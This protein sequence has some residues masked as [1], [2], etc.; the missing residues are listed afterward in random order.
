MCEITFPLEIQ[1]PKIP[2]TGEENHRAQ[3]ILVTTATT[4]GGIFFQAGALFSTENTKCWHILA[5]LNYLFCDFKLFCVLLESQITRQFTKIDEYQVCQWVIVNITHWVSVIIIIIEWLWL[6]LFASI[7]NL[8]V[9]PTHLHSTSREATANIMKVK[10]SLYCAPRN[11]FL[12][13]PRKFIFMEC[14]LWPHFVVQFSFS[15]LSIN[16]LWQPLTSVKVDVNMFGYLLLD[17]NVELNSVNSM[18]LNRQKCICYHKFALQTFNHHHHHQGLSESVSASLDYI[19]DPD[20][21]K[22][23]L[24]CRGGGNCSLFFSSSFLTMSYQLE[25]APSQSWPK[26]GDPLFSTPSIKMAIQLIIL[27]FPYFRG[28]KSNSGGYE[29]GGKNLHLEEG[30]CLM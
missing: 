25:E 19:L 10:C 18:Q 14:K 2:K 28:G 17:K 26:T 9:T 24:S 7:V 4:C 8:N 21:Y 15:V 23:W 11:M 6:P 3:L 16:S 27:I 1:T 5:N 13:F 12:N 29:G 20:A 22:G 30:I